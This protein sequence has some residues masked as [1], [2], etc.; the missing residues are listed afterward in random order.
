MGA[1]N[2]QVALVTG[3]G[4]GI[5]RSISEELAREGADVVV[6]GRRV[7]AL[8]ETVAAI[9]ES[10]GSADAA[11]VDVSVEE[12]VEASVAETVARHGGIDL[13]VNNA[14]RLM[15]FGP[16][17]EADPTEWWRDVTVNLFG[18]FLCCR[19]A[20]RRMVER[21]HGRIIVFGG[22]GS[23][24]ALP[25]RSGYGA[26]KAAL[27]EFAETMQAEAGPY[28][29]QV[30][31]IGPGLVRTEITETHVTIPYVRQL[32]PEFERLFAEGR[33]VPPTL[34]ARLCV[35]L[36]STPEAD[37][38]AGRFLSATEDYREIVRRA[39]EVVER[40]LYVVRRRTIDP[41]S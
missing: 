25:Y 1:L 3:G 24:G 40:N 35:F 16:V 27:V 14:G 19:A 22:G 5:G 11:I 21:R 34:A 12:Q 15:G 6:A 23:T 31:A 37:R 9:R 4:H 41:T 29:V 8:E 20:L 17:W 39:D 26:S 13:L 36:A 32:L 7:S 10:G 33:D 18:T 38:L 2:G 28:G 30:F